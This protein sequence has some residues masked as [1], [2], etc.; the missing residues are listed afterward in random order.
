MGGRGAETLC[1]VLQSGCESC[2]L[3]RYSFS[4]NASYSRNDLAIERYSSEGRQ[5][6]TGPQ[7][8]SKNAGGVRSLSAGMKRD[9]ARV[10][11]RLLE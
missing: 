1:A 6:K 7:F 10:L 2:Q 5:R 9:A 4:R 11:N 3:T 8:N